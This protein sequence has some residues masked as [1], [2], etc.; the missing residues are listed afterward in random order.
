MT[1]NDQLLANVGALKPTQNPQDA[2]D[3]Q[4]GQYSND[5]IEKS[6]SSAQLKRPPSTVQPFGS[7]K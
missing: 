6:R 4:T 1:Q 3:A 5:R 7:L 2:V